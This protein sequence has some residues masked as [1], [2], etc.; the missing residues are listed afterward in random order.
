VS[1]PGPPP[2]APFDLVLHHD[3]RWSH[4]GQPLRNR[5]LREAFDRG[6][7]FLP[8]EGEHGKYVVHLRH[9]RGE[10]IVE[11]AGFFVREYDPPSG[12]IA[13]SDGSSEVLDVASLQPSPIDGALLC[14]VKRDVAP[15]GLAA[16]FF[17]AAQA[18]LLHAVEDGPDGFGLRFGGALRALPKL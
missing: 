18:G 15:D 10:I 17:H 11:E 2:L 6:V 4:E 12:R 5:K 9:F 1:A 3:G 14:R 8:E 13:L 7:L 16:R